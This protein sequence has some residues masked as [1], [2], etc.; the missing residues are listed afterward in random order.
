M[1]TEQDGEQVGALSQHP[2][3]AEKYPEITRAQILNGNC[4]QKPAKKIVLQCDRIFD[5]VVKTISAGSLGSI[6]GP[7]KSDTGWQ[8]LATAGTF[9]RRCVAQALSRGDGSCH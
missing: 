5:A 8:W 3:V 1:G 7:V 4:S 9:H 6:P 2:L